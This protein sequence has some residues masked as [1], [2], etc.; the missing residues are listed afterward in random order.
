MKQ[1]STLALGAVLLCMAV[2]LAGCKTLDQA[3]NTA[4]RTIAVTQSPTAKTLSTVARAK[5]PEQALKES[6]QRLEDIR[7]LIQQLKI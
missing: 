2:V 4:E 1:T 5:A 6:L 3:L 7:L